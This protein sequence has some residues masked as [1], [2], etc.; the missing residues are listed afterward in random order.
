MFALTPS[1]IAKTCAWSMSEWGQ[2]TP[3]EEE[4]VD[5]KRSTSGGNNTAAGRLTPINMQLK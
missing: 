1:V 4:G 3:A 2:L 5:G